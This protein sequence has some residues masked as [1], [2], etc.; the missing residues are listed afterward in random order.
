MLPECFS[1]QGQSDS[2]ILA[3]GPGYC[4]PGGIGHVQGPSQMISSLLDLFFKGHWQSLKKSRRVRGRLSWT[5]STAWTQVNRLDFS[6]FQ[7]V[8]YTNCCS[9]PGHS[10]SKDHHK[11]RSTAHISSPLFDNPCS[12]VTAYNVFWALW[13]KKCVR[14]AGG[15]DDL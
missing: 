3:P 4:N 15:K 8:Y 2:G 11:Y 9:T 13:P 6:L 14:F 7:G 12:T 10:Q 1:P 5:L